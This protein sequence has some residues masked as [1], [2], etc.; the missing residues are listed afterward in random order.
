MLKYSLI[1]LPL[2]LIGV[3]IA[4]AQDSTDASGCAAANIPSGI[5]ITA[6][7]LSA[8]ADNPGDANVM[9]EIGIN[10]QVLLNVAANFGDIPAAHSDFANPDTHLKPTKNA[11]VTHAGNHLKM[12]EGEC[13]E[14]AVVGTLN[15]GMHVLV[16]EGPYASEDL[17]WWHVQYKGLLGW[18]IEGQN[19]EIWLSGAS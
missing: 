9:N 15:T 14:S 7:D 1:I 17:A 13:T 18:V 4:S 10:P 16:L 3:T 11:I 12:Y 6:D 2:L 8:P 19:N 5:V